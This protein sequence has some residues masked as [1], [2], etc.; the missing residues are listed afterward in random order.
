MTY[1]LAGRLVVQFETYFGDKLPRLFRLRRRSYAVVLHVGDGQ[2]GF[3]TPRTT[4]SPKVLGRSRVVL[5][6]EGT[7]ELASG[8]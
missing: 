1:H 7:F 5:M 2:A 3:G 4:S 6:T 8:E